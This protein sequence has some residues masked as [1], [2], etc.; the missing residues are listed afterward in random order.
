MTTRP[1]VIMKKTLSI[2]LASGTLVAGA[3]NANVVSAYNYLQDGDL[4]KAAEFIEPAISN[5]GTAG[6]EKTWRYRGDIYRLIALD[7]QHAA[8]RSQF[9]DAMQKAIESY[10]KANELDSKGSYKTEI[11]TN[12]GALQGAS[13]NAGNEAFEAKDY[14]KAITLYGQAEKIAKTFGQ[15]D[16]DA[17]FNSALAYD[18]KGDLEMA[19]K[20]YDECIQLGYPKEDVYRYKATV[21]KKQGDLDGAIAT[22][23]AGIT[24]FPGSKELVKDEVFFKLEAKRPVEEALTSVNNAIATDPK[25]PILYS[26][27]GSIYD[28]LANPK[29]GTAA[30]SE[31]DW[32]K[33]IDM[34]EADYQKSI[35]L[36]PANFDAYFNVG[37]LYNNRAAMQYEKIKDIKS[38]VEYEKAK[39][40]ADEVYFKAIPYFEKAYELR[41]DDRPTMEQLK[42]LY[43]RAGNT[44]KYDEMKA[45]LGN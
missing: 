28:E 4:A 29:E 33:Y 1:H 40:A 36:N 37:V 42:R 19:V 3:Q 16:V 21:Q 9:P 23:A 15:N 2:L 18:T 34:A 39:K 44:A 13:L 27:R 14:D 24:K 45:K 32:K 26:L 5:E 43:A 7:P 30:P 35:E 22:V 20:R 38:D 17:V 12:L 6:K 10:L 25:D 41:A 11:V 8:L 31:A